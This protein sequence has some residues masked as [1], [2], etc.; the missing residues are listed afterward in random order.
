MC[1]PETGARAHD[2]GA[3]RVPQVYLFSNGAH[4][5][6]GS[7]GLFLLLGRCLEVL[8]SNVPNRLSVLL[9]HVHLPLHK[10]MTDGYNNVEYYDNWKSSGLLTC[11]ASAPCIQS[12]GVNLKRVN[13]GDDQ[14]QNRGQ[15]ETRAG[16]THPR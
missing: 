16:S 3:V 4:F 14:R 9:G 5:G 6:L 11:G 13:T 15:K 7:L 8:S 2:S 12:L 1:L 10:S